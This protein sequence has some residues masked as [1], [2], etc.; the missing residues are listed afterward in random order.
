MAPYQ[1]RAFF[2]DER[3]GVVEASSKAGKTVACIVWLAEQAMSGK[4]GQ[5]FWWVAPIYLQAKIAYRRMRAALPRYAYLANE[6]E[7]K[8]TLLNGSV[9]WF[10]GSDKPDSLYGE[11]V[12]AAVIDEASRVKEDAWYAVRSTLTATQGPI[13]IIGNVKGRKN[14]FY[15]LSR[16][17]ESGESGGIYAKVTAWD[18]VQAGILAQEEVEDARRMLPDPIFRELFLAEPSEDGSNPFGLS[19]IRAC[20]KDISVAP[21]RNWGWDLAKSVDWTVGI[22]LDIDG[23]T[24]AL[25][26]FQKSWEETVP[27]ILQATT[28][29]ATVDSTGVGDPIVERLQK[30]RKSTFEAYHF[31]S[32]SKQRLMEGLSVAIQ[33]QEIG[34]PEGPVVD[35]LEEFEYVYTRTGVRYSAPEGLHDDCV[36]ALGLAVWNKSH[37]RVGRMGVSTLG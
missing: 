13:R 15:M 12:F 2:H 36:M 8:I 17:F 29:S 32:S 31:S 3:Y 10:K 26:R 30:E 11:D 37:A 1:L 34:F 35:E 21:S 19:A 24:A 7:L 23:V 4:D 14:W 9:I 28:R 20:V 25:Y 27:I 16:R 33:S 22:G 5:N 18:A 6:S